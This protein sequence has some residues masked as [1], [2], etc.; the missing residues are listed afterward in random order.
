MND[1]ESENRRRI[2]EVKEETAK[3]C[4]QAKQEMQQ[5]WEEYQKD[6]T[7]IRTDIGE[8]MEGVYL[9]LIH[10]Q[11]CIRDSITIVLTTRN[12]KFFISKN[13]KFYLTA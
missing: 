9:S 10:I 13:V 11:M 4:E 1:F 5:I 6:I 7:V 2:E 12:T 8:R 3:K